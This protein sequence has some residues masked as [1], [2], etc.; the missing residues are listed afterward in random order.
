MF[1]WPVDPAEPGKVSPV[2][3]GLREA[4]SHPWRDAARTPQH[5]RIAAVHGDN[6]SRPRAVN[7]KRF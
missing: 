6:S 7:R 5:R 1:G 2:R 4:G 3:L